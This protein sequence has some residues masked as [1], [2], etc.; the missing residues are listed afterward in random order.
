MTYKITS[1]AQVNA[2]AALRII[3][4]DAA[5]A[6]Q[7]VS[8]G[9]R[10]ETAADN[11]TYWSFASVLRS[12]SSSLTNIHDAL[13]VGASKVDTAY[14]AMDSLIDQLG[15]IRA[16]LVTAQESGVD[17]DKLNTS[18]TEMKTQIQT[19]VQTT[20]IAG[21]NWLYNQDPTLPTSRSVIGGFTRGANGEYQAQMISYPATQTVMVDTV[22]PSRGLLTKATDVLNAD[23][24]STGR[25]Y[26][27]LGAGSATSTGTEIK[28]DSTTT[29][30]EIA[31]MLS[32]VDTMLSTL[33][34][35]AAGLGTMSARISDRID[36]TANLSD[37]I[38]KGVGSLVDTDM[39]EASTRQ[40]ALETQQQ[41]GVQAISILNTAASKVLILL[42]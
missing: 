10:V 23:G 14:T 27:L 17:K 1:A 20:S 15:D 6:Q 35:T 24:T 2:L 12:D 42:Q 40:K 36:Y 22:D 21:E 34:T 13:G 25:S 7:Q 11:A 39:D 37:L 29:P 18:L 33:T 41:M 38:D 4:K 9:Y 31:D 19:T 26:Y 3:N 28:L 16:T 8:S 5:T 30:E 32:A